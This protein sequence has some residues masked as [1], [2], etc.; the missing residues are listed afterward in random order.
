MPKKSFLSLLK[1]RLKKSSMAIAGVFTGNHIDDELWEELEDRLIMA[2]IGAGLTNTLL[3]KVKQDRTALKNPQSL[4]KALIKEASSIFSP[5]QEHIAEKPLVML[6]IG[7]NG[8]GKTTTIAKLAQASIDKGE[9]VLV[10]AADTFRA[11][12]ID[13]LRQWTD[14]LNIPLIAQQEGS[15]PASVAYDTVN[16][17]IAKNADIAIIDTAGRLHTKHNLMEE[18]KK[19]HRVVNKAKE[20]A[21]HEVLLVLDGTS[22]QNALSQ[23]KAF[24]EA[25]RVTALAITKLDGTAKGGIVMRVAHELNIPVKY[26]GLGEKSGDLIPFNAE[27]YVEAIFSS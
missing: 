18:L 8:A 5:A 14:R 11:A 6:V 12:A 17:A 25:I 16:A 13:Q 24:N 19:I 26:I 15:D 21:P 2:D 22:G 9:K 20:G 23:A 1:E 4:Q 10:G 3:T 27:E 7:V